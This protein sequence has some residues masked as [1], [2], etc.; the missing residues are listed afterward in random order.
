MVTI[1]WHLLGTKANYHYQIITKLHFND[2]KIWKMFDKNPGA[3]I[4]YCKII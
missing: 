2:N 1:K 3:A 4:A